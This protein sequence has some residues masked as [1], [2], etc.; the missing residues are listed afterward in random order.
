MVTNIPEP[1]ESVA[2]QAWRESFETERSPGPE[3]A[4][5][6][7]VNL[8]INMAQ[9]LKAVYHTTKLYLKAKVALLT[10]GATP[11]EFAELAHDAVEVVIATLNAVRET[12][13]DLPYAA[14]VVLSAAEDRGLTPSE[15]ELAL[16]AFVTDLEWEK[17]PWYMGFSEKN[18]DNARKAL[19]N[20]G[21]FAALLTKLED[22][23]WLSHQGDKLVFKARHYVWGLKQ[24]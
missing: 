15:F 7:R 18:V 23:D 10:G 4:L 1:Q 12:M 9:A 14:C 24:G 20:P 2:L 3:Q 16:N 13:S 5:F 21:A 17:L 8:R 6:G 22:D 11:W 19:S